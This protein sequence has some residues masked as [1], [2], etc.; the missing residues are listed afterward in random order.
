MKYAVEMVSDAII[1]ITKFHKDWFRHSDVNR[2][3]TQTGRRSHKPTLGKYANKSKTCKG[4]YVGNFWNVLISQ[5][6]FSS[7]CGLLV[8]LDL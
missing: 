7:T 5:G 4:G 6:G 2:W 8:R 1:Y 3:D